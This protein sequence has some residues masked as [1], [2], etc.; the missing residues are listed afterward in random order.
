M[1]DSEKP[2]RSAAQKAI[3]YCRTASARQIAQGRDD[4]YQEALGRACAETQGMEVVRVFRDKGA[5]GCTTDRPKVRKMIDYILS[6]PEDR[7][8]VLVPGIERLA[9]DQSTLAELRAKLRDVGAVLEIIGDDR[10]PS[11]EDSFFATILQALDERHASLTAA[12]EA[13]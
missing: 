10:Q 8:V 6:H 13:V 5:S 11:P 9:R 2:T 12:K 7:I 1:R 4:D 3:V